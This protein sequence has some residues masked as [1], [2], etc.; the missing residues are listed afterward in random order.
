M[1]WPLK[2]GRSGENQFLRRIDVLEIVLRAEPVKL[3]GV[4]ISSG[5]GVKRYPDSLEEF[6]RALDSPVDLPGVR[7]H[8]IHYERALPLLGEDVVKVDVL[9]VVRIPHGQAPEFF[10][11]GRKFRGAVTRLMDRAE[12]VEQIRESV[13]D[14]ARIEVT[15]SKHAGVRAARVVR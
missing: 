15:E 13:Q 8:Q 10:V 7:H 4:G 11:C 6:F 12:D 2:V 14:P 9:F 5:A 3:V 1:E